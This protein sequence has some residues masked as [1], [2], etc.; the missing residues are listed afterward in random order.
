MFILG[1]LHVVVRC[2]QG[3]SARTQEECAKGR[4]SARY[5]SASS[6][7]MQPVPAEVTACL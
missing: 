1:S 2:T 3:L 7:A 5:F 6:A 4:Q